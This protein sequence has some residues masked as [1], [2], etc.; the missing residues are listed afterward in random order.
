MADANPSNRI[1]A[2][3][4][5][6]YDFEAP[7]VVMLHG[8]GSGG[9][10]YGR[11][12]EPVCAC[13]DCRRTFRAK[14]DETSSRGNWMLNYEGACPDCGASLPG[15]HPAMHPE[16]IGYGLGRPGDAD[17]SGYRI[18][19]P[20]D[21]R[22]Y[23][24][25]RPDGDFRI[26]DAISYRSV[27]ITW[28]KDRTPTVEF[29]GGLDKV[30]YA[31]GKAVAYRM[32]KDGVEA[33]PDGRTF[34]QAPAPG[35]P[36]PRD[37]DRSRTMS[38]WRSM[39]DHGV[40]GGANWIDASGSPVSNTDGNF[41]SAAYAAIARTYGLPIP[42]IERRYGR[43]RPRERG[44]TVAEPVM[45]NIVGM[46]AAYP[47]VF[48]RELSRVDENLSYAAKR[49]EDVPDAKAREE[50]LSALV[51][52]MRAIYA[53][54]RAVSKEL[55]ACRY[56][57]EVEASLRAITFGDAS[58]GDGKHIK[59]AGSQQEGY[60]GKYLKS[61]FN[62]NPYVAAANAYACRK[63]GVKDV[64]GVRA[65]FEGARA[66]GYPEGVIPPVETAA[67]LGFM[68]MLARTRSQKDLVAQAYAD[69]HSADMI[70]DAAVIYGGLGPT[71]L[72]RAKED[73]ARSDYLD[74]MNQARTFFTGVEGKPRSLEDFTSNDTFRAMFGSRI[75]QVGEI[76]YQEWLARPE[77]VPNPYKQCRDGRP[78][79]PNRT[80]AEIHDE[81]SEIGNRPEEMA[82]D[83][84]TPYTEAQR[85][86]V[87]RVVEGYDVHLARS[88]SELWAAGNATQTC[89]YAS[90]KKTAMDG[91]TPIV[92]L[93]SPEGKI[94]GLV[95]LSK[96]MATAHQV[97]GFRNTALCGP[98]MEAARAWLD[99]TGIQ[100]DAAGAEDVRWFGYENHYFHGNHNWHQGQ[101]RPLTAEEAARARHRAQVGISAEDFLAQHAR[102]DE[103][104]G[105]ERPARPA[106][107]A[108]QVE[109]AQDGAV[110]GA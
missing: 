66:A 75:D 34:V 4:I 26:T 83:A 11:D 106:P 69:S 41:L 31:P 18:D 50:R 86:K 68:K 70:R 7:S 9:S 87:D 15:D 63:L 40:N 92:L 27:F 2:D 17:P 90:Y 108:P 20:V 59:V 30:E 33:R 71:K 81:L 48:R 42:A 65:M 104:R 107:P 55:H 21:R 29:G 14:L 32:G 62:V 19:V 64:N 94:E 25:F 109:F 49:G 85:R 6:E 60:V 58:G 103:L 84:P 47:G 80:A 23:A 10:G 95:E 28:S 35:V 51:S 82:E 46:A 38:S 99:D 97:K 61:R 101:D 24:G 110:L 37:L 72:I 98:V 76:C 79:F 89:V 74:F 8:P 67:C 53:M 3:L 12:D 96:S 102:N 36:I 88:L 105:R 13:L 93:T 52:A 73:A 44:V 1:E 39:P 91:S 78:L 22:A 5:A 54:D 45:Q 43:L 77:L 16:R 100:P 57:S 56:P